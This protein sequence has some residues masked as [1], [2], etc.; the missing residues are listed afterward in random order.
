MTSEGVA[1]RRPVVVLDACVLVP[2]GLRD[3]LLSCADA[4]VFTPR[5]QSEIEDE[6]RRNGARYYADRRG[7]PV[8]QAREAV[9]RV[10]SAMNEA[11]A[12]A[13]LRPS[14][15]VPVVPFMVNDARDRHVLAAAVGAS[16][17][18][19][20]TLNR[21]HFPR[22]TWPAGV[23]VK[24]PD[25]FLSARLVDSQEPV[26]EAMRRMAARRRRPPESVAELA[27]RMASEG[28]L[29]R[30]GGLLL[31]RVETVGGE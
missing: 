24:T 17:T 13:R 9:E 16:A 6:V 27:R 10:L 29:S 1:G 31:R 23:V 20:L 14:E 15:W 28:S 4:G 5:W 19:M 18:H 30:F 11:F 8:V 3:V 2:P 21:R 25:D 22:A 12:A 26:L 7:L